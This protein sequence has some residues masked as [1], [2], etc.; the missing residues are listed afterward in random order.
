MWCGHFRKI[1]EEVRGGVE[2]SMSTWNG[3]WTHKVESHGRKI[4]W[5][6]HKEVAMAKKRGDEFQ[7]CLGL[8]GW[9]DMEVSEWET[10]VWL[11]MFCSGSWE[12]AITIFYGMEYKKRSCFVR[13]KMRLQLW[14]NVSSRCLWDGIETNMCSR[15]WMILVWSWQKGFGWVY[16]FLSNLST[17]RSRGPWEWMKISQGYNVRRANC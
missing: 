16:R 17:S 12:E 15:I 5:G 9:L 8:G 6:W 11:L 13:E 14:T 2:G 7:R 4:M 10:L 3:R 1:P